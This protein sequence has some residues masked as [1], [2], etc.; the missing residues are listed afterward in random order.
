MYRVVSESAIASTTT[1]GENAMK[2]LSFE[3]HDLL[4]VQQ[5][6]EN[7]VILCLVLIML[8]VLRV[9]SCTGM[10]PPRPAAVAAVGGAWGISAGGALRTQALS[11]RWHCS[12]ADSESDRR[13]TGSDT[14][15]ASDTGTGTEHD[16]LAGAGGASGCCTHCPENLPT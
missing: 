13:V 16:V 9:Q 6:F 8:R 12:Q 15:S 5:C 11:S 10:Q 3:T 4:S 1:D 14:G 7:A 2:R